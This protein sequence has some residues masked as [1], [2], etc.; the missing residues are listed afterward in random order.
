MILTN[1][2]TVCSQARRLNMTY[3]I[4]PFQKNKVKFDIYFDI[5]KN[6]YQ[7]GFIVKGTSLS[8][9]FNIQRGFIID[10]ILPKAQYNL[11]CSILNLKAT[12][13]F[14]PFSTA[15]FFN[16]FNNSIPNQLLPLD[17]YRDTVLQVA[18]TKYSVEEPD[19]LYYWGKTDWNLPHNK[20]KGTRS[21]QN[22]EK[23][24]ILYPEIYDI[25]KNK[26][27]SIKY[28]SIKNDKIFM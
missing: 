2:R 3:C 18:I 23:T 6:P 4:F 13:N 12:D 28:T 8:I 14:T 1:L 11:L 7:L 20:G 24:R 19:N 22:L 25:I 26:N 5:N 21:A 9:W 27:I 16:E 17:L 15:A 10:C